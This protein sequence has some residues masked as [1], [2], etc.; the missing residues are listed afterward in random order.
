[1]SKYSKELLRKSFHILVTAFMI[2]WFYFYDD[3]K[4]IVLTVFAVMV[5]LY[6][7]LYLASYIPGVS[8][9]VNAR[10][11]GEYSKSFAAVMIMYIIVATVCWGFLGQRHLGIACILAW[12]PGDAAAALIGQRFGKHKIGRRKRKSLEG[13]LAMFVFSFISV[14]VVLFIYG[15]YGVVATVIVALMTALAS[16]ITELLV[17][18]GFDTF[19]CPVAAMVVIVI[20]E[21]LL[22]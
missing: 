5:L 19:Y 9:F 13:S 21:M 2:A 18:N 20:S 14:L 4:K 11:K 6:P 3:W 1:M 12:G 7:L 17:E 22:R 15:R 16:T 10:K 8:Q